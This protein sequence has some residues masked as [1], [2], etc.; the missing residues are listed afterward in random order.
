MLK[1]I[2]AHP[3]TQ[4]M[5]LDSPETSKLRRKIIKDKDFL[6]KIYLEWYQSIFAKI[7]IDI[8]GRILELGSGGGFLG[9]IF[10]EVIKSDIIYLSNIDVIVDAHKLPFRL[11]S[12]RAIVMTNVLHHIPQPDTFFRSAARCVR[13]GGRIT[14]IEPWVTTWSRFVYTKLHHEPFDPNVKEWQFPSQG[15]LSGAN[16]AIPWIIFQRDKDKFIQLFSE[17]SILEIKLIMPFR[18]LVSGG[19]SLRSFMPDFTF[20]FW[21]WFEG[22][23]NPMMD[24]IALFALIS[25]ERNHNA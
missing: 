8:P 11:N 2:L 16:S 15:P 19:V 10:P 3:L 25:L 24:K 18:Y 14:M 22:L 20:G 21:K 7:S 12:L 13:P 6:Y 5:D 17:W 9:E 1:N 4:G 23:L